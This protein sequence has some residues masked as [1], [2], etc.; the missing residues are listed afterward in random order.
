[1]SRMRCAS[2][3]GWSLCSQVVHAL[4]ARSR[5]ASPGASLTVAVEVGVVLRDGVAPCLDE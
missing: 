4:C 2:D 3:Q 1:M 5:F